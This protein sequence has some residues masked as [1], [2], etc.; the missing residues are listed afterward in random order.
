MQTTSDKKRFRRGNQADGVQFLEKVGFLEVWCASFRV[1][2]VN[3]GELRWGPSYP[4][5]ARI[6]PALF[7]LQNIKIPTI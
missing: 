7:S 4:V 6:N 1:F 2:P 3:S 5:S